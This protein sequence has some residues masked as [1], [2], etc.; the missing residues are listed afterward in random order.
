MITSY[1]LAVDIRFAVVILFCLT[2]A[3]L[4]MA[5]VVTNQRRKAKKPVYFAKATVLVL[6]ALI[7]LSALIGFDID[8]VRS[9]WA[10]QVV[11]IML[12]SLIA[13]SILSDWYIK[14]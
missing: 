8:F 2:G 11:L 10:T 13:A 3:G 14:K 12:I 6:A 5:Y 9:G 7:Y 1:P 4:S